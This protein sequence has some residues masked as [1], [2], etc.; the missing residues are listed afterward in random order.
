MSPFANISLLLF[1]LIEIINSKKSLIFFIIGLKNIILLTNNEKKVIGLDGFG[2]KII[3]QQ[4][5]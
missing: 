2:L 3:D 4:S 5:F 1:K